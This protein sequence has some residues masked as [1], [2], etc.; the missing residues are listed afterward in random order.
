MGLFYLK[1]E[2][3]P[4]NILLAGGIGIL[5]LVT[6]VV[7]YLDIVRPLSIVLTQVQGLL[8]KG[9]YKRIFTDRVD[10][11]G[12]LAYFFNKVTEGF[13]QVSYDIKDRQRMLAELKL[14]AQL[15]LDIL[16]AHNPKILGLQVEAKTKPATE[17]GGDLF[18]FITVK[19]KTFIYIGDA[20]GHGTVAG[21]VMTMVNSLVTVFSDM[22]MSAYDILVNVNK[23]LKKWLRKAVY[24]T[25]VMLCWDSKEN[26]MTYVG[27]GHEHII[28]YHYD[29]G[30]CDSILSGGIAL[31]MIPDN[32]KVI[33]EQEIK[34][35]DHDYI[36]LYSDGIT[37]AKGKNGELYGLDRLKAAVSDYAPQYSAEGVNFHIAKDVSN[38]M[39]GM[40]QK[41]DMSL[42]VIRRDVDFK[43]GQEDRSTNW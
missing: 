34:L 29:T 3:V 5:L 35:N 8:T 9:T 1:P 19:D 33:K 16:P 26:K 20:T 17:I 15:Q 31:G 4:F 11:I 37:E 42:I 40:E 6:V 22:N 13:G 41:D 23:Y 30:E 36:V 10:E 28:V 21:L 18:N 24:M 12:I 2:L 32:S 39:E 14:A 25:M 38:F 43:A 7:C 27:A